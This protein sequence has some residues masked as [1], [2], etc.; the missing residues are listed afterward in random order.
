MTEFPKIR[1]VGLGGVLV[2]FGDK[3][4]DTVNRAAIAFRGAVDALA[5]PQIEES[6]STLV[7]AFFRVDLATHG[8]APL[9]GIRWAG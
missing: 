6:S 7:S 1:S 4:T 2:T 8:S 5:W 9:Q 3:A